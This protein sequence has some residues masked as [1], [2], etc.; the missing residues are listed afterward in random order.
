MGANDLNRGFT[1]PVRG[2]AMPLVIRPID[3]QGAR[4][5][6][7][8]ALP[9]QDALSSAP[10]PVLKRT[11]LVLAAIVATAVLLRK[12]T[13]AGAQR[14]AANY[15]HSYRVRTWSDRRKMTWDQIC[16]TSPPP[17]SPTALLLWVASWTS[18]AVWI[19]YVTRVSIWTIASL[20]APEARNAL[21]GVAA[22]YPG[23]GGGSS[24]A[25]AITSVTAK[26]APKLAHLDPGVVEKAA[27]GALGSDSAPGMISIGIR[28]I[29]KGGVI[30]KIVSEVIAPIRAT[31]S[32]AH[33]ATKQDAITF[34]MWTT[35][36]AP[37]YAGAVAIAATRAAK[38][39][40]KIRPIDLHPID[41]LA[42]AEG[43]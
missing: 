29:S 35:R 4:P 34:L 39:E 6:Q 33:G 37:L 41:A 38:S 10:S 11:S 13:S 2:I 36:C 19:Y 1:V 24:L 12:V 18:F 16:A 40:G 42:C 21:E 17:T 9:S 32:Q 26:I 5:L 7:M 30:A 14:V 25:K 23:M 43:A 15:P 22:M 8:D 27:A 31:V 3:A 20:Y 28:S